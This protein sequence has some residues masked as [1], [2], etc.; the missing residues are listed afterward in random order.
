M[1]LTKDDAKRFDCFRDAPNMRMKLTTRAVALLVL[2]AGAHVAFLFGAYGTGL[3]GI[4]HALPYGVV[5]FIWLACSSALAGWGYFRL[6]SGLFKAI[7]ARLLLS[8]LALA[9]SFYL[10]VFFAFNMFGT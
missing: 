10:G 5:V 7:W 3:F 8:V 9:S 2:V 1:G 4:A 6:S